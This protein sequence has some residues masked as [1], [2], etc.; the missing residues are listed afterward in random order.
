[1]L[2]EKQ[3]VK[4]VPSYFEHH[5][6][7]APVGG[8]GHGAAF[9]GGLGG[10]QGHD[11]LGIRQRLNLQAVFLHQGHGGRVYALKVTCRETSPITGA[12]GIVVSN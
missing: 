6:N 11:G 3:S 5:V 1:M 12:D 8:D 2:G 7:G 9:W 4:G 10:H